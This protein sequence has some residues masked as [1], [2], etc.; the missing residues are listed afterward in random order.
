MSEHKINIQRATEQLN[1]QQNLPILPK[2]MVNLRSTCRNKA[3]HGILDFAGKDNQT[4]L[5]FVD[6]RQDPHA[7]LVEAE[8]RKQGIEYFRLCTEEYPESI[9]LSASYTEQGFRGEIVQGSTSLDLDR[10][11]GFWYRRPGTPIAHED[12]DP[13]YRAY[14]VSESMHMIQG[15]FGA[16]RDRNWVNH[17]FD[18]EAASRKLRQLKYAQR[19]GMKIPQTLVSNHPEL[20]L[21][22]A[23]KI[24]GPVLIKSFDQLVV[25]RDDKDG[26]VD[27]GFYASLASLEDLVAN[28]HDL[29]RAPLI[30]QEYVPKRREW[31]IVSIGKKLFAAAIYSQERGDTIVDYRQNIEACRMEPMSLPSQVESSIHEMN[32]C[33]NLKMAHYD[34]IETTDGDFYFLEVNPGGQWGWL[35][36]RLNFPIAQQLIKQL[37]GPT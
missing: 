36:E 21:D 32:A 18:E 11:K 26:P 34:F 14:V 2:A 27:L 4:M 29:Q 30:F 19:I 37:M 6:R 8:C 22:F 9:A 13:E 16:L 1:N 5:L 7:D 17:P 31:R 25:D 35:Q 20:I 33:F 28:Q 23:R 3:N 12:L 15:L 10:V 24:G